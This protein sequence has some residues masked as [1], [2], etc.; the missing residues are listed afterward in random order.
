MD[1]GCRSGG[2]GARLH[3]AVRRRLATCFGTAGLEF[4]A[5]YRQKKGDQIIIASDDEIDDND[6]DA[7]TVVDIVDAAELNEIPMSN[8][9]LMGWGKVFLKA[10]IDK[11]KEDG[12]EDR[13]PAFK[14]EST[15]MFKFIVSKA[16][17]FQF[18]TGKSVNMTASLAFSYQKE[19][20]DEGPTF[21]FFKDALKIVKL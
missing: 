18:Y 21:L 10:V 9:D 3:V 6:D 16:D 5:N 13:I 12:K 17:E 14:K 15:E 1:G 8:K 7:V 11:L 2:L 19:Q 4:K 20:D